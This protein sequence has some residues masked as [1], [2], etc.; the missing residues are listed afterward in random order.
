M[1]RIVLSNK[2]DINLRITDVGSGEL[3]GNMLDKYVFN[4]NV[5]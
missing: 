4:T 2:R 5:S 3:R 1:K